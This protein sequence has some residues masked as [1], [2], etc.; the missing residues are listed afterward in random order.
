MT[1]IE[2]ATT[3]KLIVTSGALL[4]TGANVWAADTQAP[5]ARVL[6]IHG[7]GVH[8]TVH[9]SGAAAEPEDRDR[10]AGGEAGIVGAADLAGTTADTSARRPGAG[11]RD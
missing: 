6:G 1:R 7:E 2:S 9:R 8:G 11:H 10:P 3:E 5:Y 4:N